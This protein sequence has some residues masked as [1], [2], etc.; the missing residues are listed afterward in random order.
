MSK[1]HAQIAL[2]KVLDA[3]VAVQMK[4]YTLNLGN[5]NVKIPD[6]R[7][8]G[9]LS[10]DVSIEV[11]LKDIKDTKVSYLLIQPKN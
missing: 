9:H 3:L 2:K 1:I 7:M 6:F 10:V 5:A 8:T 4:M 11:S